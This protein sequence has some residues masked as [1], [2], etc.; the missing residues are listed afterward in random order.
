MKNDP[1]P[2]SDDDAL[3]FR[4]TSRRKSA[5]PQNPEQ[6]REQLID[7]AE[8]C[9]ER[10]GMSKITMDDI[11]RTAN[12]SRPAIYRHFGDRDGL[13][14]AV[15]L[16]RAEALIERGRAFIATQPTLSEA[17]VEGTLFL[18]DGTRNDPFVKLLVSSEHMGLPNQV[19]GVSSAALEL[20]ARIWD[21]LLTVAQERGE[22][23]P[24]R[25]I[26]DLSRWITLISIMFV[27]RFDLIT[28]DTDLHRQ[29]L[30]EFLLPAF[31]PNW[32]PPHLRD[33]AD[34]S[35]LP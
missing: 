19:T 4:W 31:Q 9:F 26:K 10:Y 34:S 14:M 6:V 12:V 30:R 2:L 27:G 11:A 28:D 35:V 7:A 20:G 22:L 33:P 25:D 29:M 32:V 15:V 13:I 24:E 23:A 5:A 17:L 18:V 1:A 16:R 21:P 3:P 8:A